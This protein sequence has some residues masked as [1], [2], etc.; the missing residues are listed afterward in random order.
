[1]FTLTDWNQ[2]MFTKENKIKADMSCY[3]SSS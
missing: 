2:A 1:M 3:K